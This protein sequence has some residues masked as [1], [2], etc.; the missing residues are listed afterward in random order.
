M[1]GILQ[2]WRRWRH[3]IGPEVFDNEARD[4]WDDRHPHDCSG[5]R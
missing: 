3:R 1:S 5:K 2:W 4:V